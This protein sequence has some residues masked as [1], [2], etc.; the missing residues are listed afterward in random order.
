MQNYTENA[1]R[2]VPLTVE[3]VWYFNFFEVKVHTCSFFIKDIF[4]LWR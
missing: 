1:D 3:N 4:I 2:D